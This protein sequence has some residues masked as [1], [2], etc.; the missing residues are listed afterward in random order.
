MQAEWP[1]LWLTIR[2]NCCKTIN[3]K[4]HLELLVRQTAAQKLMIDLERSMDLLL[5]LISYLCWQ[6]P[7]Y[8]QALWNLC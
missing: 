5:G 3:E 2:L 4:R 1:F 7:V 6:V 8:T